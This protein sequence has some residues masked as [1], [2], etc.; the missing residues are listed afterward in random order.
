MIMKMEVI[1]AYQ[2]MLD[3]FNRK[4]ELHQRAHTLYKNRDMKLFTIPLMAVQFLNAIIPQIAQAVPAMDKTLSIIASSLAAMSAIWLGFQAK[5][6][7]AERAE[8]HK[9]AASIYQHL[10]VLTMVEKQ[11]EK[12]TNA[13]DQQKF[14]N[15]QDMVQNLEGKAKDDENLVPVRISKAMKREKERE[16]EKGKEKDASN[17]VEEKEEL[18]KVD[19]KLP[20]EKEGGKLPLIPALTHEKFP[21]NISNTKSKN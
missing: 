6:R 18:N 20:I 21:S 9:N 17:K 16:Q 12:M 11:K 14:F 2:G 15:F 4:R 3:R 5:K 8:S 10:A 13:N 1:E 7:Y 19:T